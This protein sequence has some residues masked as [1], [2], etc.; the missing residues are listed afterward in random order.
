L[1]L[2]LPSRT[3][4]SDGW[5]RAQSHRPASDSERIPVRWVFER[6]AGFW[7][8]ARA[9]RTQQPRLSLRSRLGAFARARDMLRES[10]VALFRAMAV[11][12]TA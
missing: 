7:A 8:H 2:V 6:Y 5:H 4:V 1:G 10:G 12:A 11:R 9:D 3:E